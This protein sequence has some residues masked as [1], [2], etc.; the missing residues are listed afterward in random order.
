PYGAGRSG[1][2]PHAYGYIDVKELKVREFAGR[3]LWPSAARHSPGELDDETDIRVPLP[4]AVA[5]GKTLTLDVR[6]LA[7]LPEIIERT[8][9]SGSFHLIAQ[10]F[11]K[12]AK[13]EPDGRWAH[14]AFHAQSEFYA[15]FGDYRVEL[16][17]PEA[18][19]VGA[20]GRR[21]SEQV[22]NGRRKLI[23]EARSV[24]DFAWTAWDGFH[25]RHE[26]IA[27]VAVRL[28]YPAGHEA[29]AERTLASVRFALPHFNRRYGRYPYP[30]LTVVH[31]PRNARAAGGMEY[32]TLITTGGPW[33]YPLLGIRA[34]ETVTIHELAH[35]WFYGLVASN[36][37][38]WPFLD[39]G[40]TSYVESAALHSAFA[41]GSLAALP[42]FPIAIESG[43]RYLGA[44]RA[45]DEAV[46]APAARFEDFTALGALVYG[47]S[48]T[49]LRTF[50]N[51]YGED[52]LARALGRYARHYRF[53]HP[54]PKHLVAALRET[55]GNDAAR[56]LEQALFERGTIDYVVREVA[57][58]RARKA[59]GVFDRK[60][61]RETLYPE[62]DDSSGDWIGRVAVYRYGELELPVEV[63]LVAQDGSRERRRWDGRGTWT[64]LNYR[65]KS[66]LVS[67][68]VDPERR[69][70]LD[71]NLFNNTFSTRTEQTPR[72]L[73]RAVYWCELLL[74]VIGP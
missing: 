61:G 73:E 2:R 45:K 40:L 3:D 53:E 33:Y 20:S 49:I 37:H 62:Q 31:P 19:V 72:V 29:N 30:V 50:A 32:P 26:N 48:A 18:F 5:P 64:A 7:Q 36:E 23:Y 71:D 52:K 16:D 28:L 10:W 39:E 43:Y 15:D 8:G 44:S 57:S 13:L 9:H 24:H 1:A 22:L 14:F 66:R 54:S 41:D 38:A 67:A 27:G 21:V 63:E 17:V 68:R 12:L 56:A 46:A 11:P 34:I 35:Q 47:R 51:V 55:L 42:G 59:A 69:I 60:T 6:F 70:L 65:G 74:G 25:E 58:T 4:E